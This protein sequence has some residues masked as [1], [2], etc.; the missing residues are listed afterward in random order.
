MGRKDCCVRIVC[1]RETYNRY[2][3][4]FARWQVVFREALRNNESK[5]LT[6][7]D[8]LN[9]MLDIVERLLGRFSFVRVGNE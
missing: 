9:F 5:R 1:T 3:N 7:E 8:F 4:L 2:Y 6:H